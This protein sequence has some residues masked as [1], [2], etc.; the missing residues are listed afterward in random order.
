[1]EIIH[2]E[3]Q[4]RVLRY[5]SWCLEGFCAMTCSCGKLKIKDTG[6]EERYGT[7]PMPHMN[8]NPASAFRT[9]QPRNLHVAKG[10][11]NSP[12]ERS[13]EESVFLFDA[14]CFR[15]LWLAILIWTKAVESC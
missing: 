11:K 6:R 10:K 15:S 1:M 5:H 9:S 12:M 7:G 2:T 8:V 4:V 13:V 3:L 14:S